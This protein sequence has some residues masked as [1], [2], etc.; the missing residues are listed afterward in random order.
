M[1]TKPFAF[2]VSKW[3]LIEEK[4][5]SNNGEREEYRVAIGEV[6]N[7]KKE[8]IRYIEENIYQDVLNVLINEDKQYRLYQ[9]LNQ[10]PPIIVKFKN[11][12]LMHNSKIQDYYMRIKAA[13]EDISTDILIKAVAEAKSSNRWS[14]KKG[15]GIRAL[16]ALV[17]AK[18]G[19]N[20]H[21]ELVLYTVKSSILEADE[22]PLGIHTLFNEMTDDQIVDFIGAV[23]EYS[24][25]EETSN[26]TLGKLLDTHKIEEIEVEVNKAVTTRY[27]LGMLA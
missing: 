22:D 7:E 6:R 5:V 19:V 25:A 1:A 11:D 21:T 12:V 14:A 26:E 2:P 20:Y 3:G 17:R 27:F 15:D 18:T 23:K 4:P 16:E 13:L 9:N 10:V 8:T 24:I